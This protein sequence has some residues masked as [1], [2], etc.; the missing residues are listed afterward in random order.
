MMRTIY[1]CTECKK[2][3]GI[4]FDYKEGDNNGIEDDDMF[5]YDC[6]QEY[7]EDAD[8]NERGI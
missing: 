1:L 7:C 4:K 6:Y 3:I 2:I 5:C 8:K